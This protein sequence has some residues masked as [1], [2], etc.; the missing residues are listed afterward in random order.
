MKCARSTIT[1]LWHC[2]PRVVCILKALSAVLGYSADT[3]HRKLRRDVP[4]SRRSLRLLD[5]GNFC[6]KTHF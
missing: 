1:A 5:L 3:E 4:K 2:S 6:D